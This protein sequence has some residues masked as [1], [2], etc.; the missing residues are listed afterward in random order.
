MNVRIPLLRLKRE[1]RAV[2]GEVQGLGPG[3]DRARAAAVGRDGGAGRWAG[4]D[5]R[6]GSGYGDRLF[7]DSARPPGTGLAVRPRPLADSAARRWPQED[8][9]ERSDAAARS[10]GVGGAHRLG[11]PDVAFAVDLQRMG[12][13]VSRQLVAELLVAAGYSLQANRKTREGSTHPDRDAQFRY[14][15]RQVRRFQAATQPV[16][17]V[18]TKKKELVGDFKNAGRQWRPTG[19][20]TPVRVHDFLIPER[21]KAIPYGV[22]DLTRNAGWVSVGID[23]DTATFAA[24]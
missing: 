7:H 6:G 1:R 23:H 2:P 12:H 16:I 21:G 8:A 5:H 19:Q 14:L 9:G 13:R 18:D 24:R 22:Y 17:S 3:A 15:N 4:R 10:R 11:R 20:P